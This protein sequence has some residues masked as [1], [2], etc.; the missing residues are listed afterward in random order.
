MFNFVFVFA[1]LAT[2]LPCLTPNATTLPDGR[3][4][5]SATLSQDLSANGKTLTP[6]GAAA[7]VTWNSG[8]VTGVGMS[9][10]A[11]ATFDGTGGL[12][13]A[14]GNEPSNIDAQDFAVSFWIRLPDASKP[15][16]R[17]PIVG[18]RFGCDDE[19]HWV[20]WFQGNRIYEIR[21]EMRNTLMPA[22]FQALDV[23]VD[24]VLNDTQWHFIVAFRE[25]TT[26]KLAVDGRVVGERSF[27]SVANLTQP[28]RP[29]AIGYWDKSCA[30]H[31]FS[32]QMA[33]V[34]LF[35][36]KLPLCNATA[37]TSA[38]QTSVAS[39]QTAAPTSVATQTP[40]IGTTTTQTTASTTGATNTTQQ[41]T[42]AASAATAQ[43]SPTPTEPDSQIGAIVGGVVAALVLVAI[44]VG[45][46]L[47]QRRRR[48]DNANTRSET[49][50]VTAQ[51]QSATSSPY[52]STL[53]VLN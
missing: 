2:A 7:A 39:T 3:W 44:V 32:G 36:R 12:Q 35:V 50:S 25:G 47:F 21:F 11:F 38:S 27:A 53:A 18:Q 48:G 10:G 24:A 1:A 28:R 45:V 9:P 4:L 41:T 52:G 20:V 23:T 15:C 42:T 49:G 33:D 46:F 8:S 5:T 17:C 34:R 26:L 29:L 31:F 19:T 22:G 14:N 13:I 43:V 37:T 6:V 30:K 51:S 40:V 16:Y